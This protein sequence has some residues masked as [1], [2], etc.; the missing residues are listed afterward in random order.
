MSV[1]NSVDTSVDKFVDNCVDNLRGTGR[2]CYVGGTSR[3]T[4][5]INA[6]TYRIDGM[7]H[8]A[9]GCR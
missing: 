1:D 8:N 6:M 2:G 4:R 9:R 3:S 5:G 7:A